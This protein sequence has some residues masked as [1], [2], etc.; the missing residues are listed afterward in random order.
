MVKHLKG[1]IKSLEK[2]INF[3]DNDIVIDIG[4]NDATTLK[5][6]SNKNIKNWY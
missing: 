4:S 3:V 6:Y 5:S 1:K 2:I